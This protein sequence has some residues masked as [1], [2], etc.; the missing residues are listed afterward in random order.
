MDIRKTTATP[1][2]ASV[3]TDSTVQQLKDC[4]AQVAELFRTKPGLSRVSLSFEDG[5]SKTY[6]RIG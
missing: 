3:E 1:V 4:N 2:P 6:Q 5:G